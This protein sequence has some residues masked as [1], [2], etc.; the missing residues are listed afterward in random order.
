MLGAWINTA[1]V[2]IGG[3]LGL[4]LGSRVPQRLRDTVMRGIGLCTLIIGAQGALGTDS[5]LTLI[6]CIVLGGLLG[7]GINIEKRLEGLGGRAERLL[8]GNGSARD[9]LFVQGFMTASLLFCVGPMSIVGPLESGLSGNHATQAAKAIM[10]GTAAVFL[11][12]ALGPGVLLSAATVLVYQGAITLGAS[13]LAPLLT[14]PVIV[15]MSA[16]GGVIIMGIGLNM[17]E[18][19]K[20]RAGNLL[21]AIFL[22]IAYLPL[23][24]WVGGLF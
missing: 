24:A 9:N 3:L 7:E 1:A 22:P 2:I 14:G 18:A 11:S 4:L 5:V 13:L 10:D 23:A 15:E 21:P 17:T 12:A 6:I 8:Y 16:V 20:I 19:A